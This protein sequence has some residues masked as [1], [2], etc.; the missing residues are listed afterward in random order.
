MEFGDF[1]LEGRRNNHLSQR[2]LADSAGVGIN[3]IGR[4]ERG[5]VDATIGTA[6]LICKALGEDYL[7][8]RNEGEET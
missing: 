4:V 7:I 8:E 3:T 1:I 6:R 2:E 5:Q